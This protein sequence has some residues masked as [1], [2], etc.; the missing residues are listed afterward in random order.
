MVLTTA[1]VS[2]I[3]PRPFRSI[4]TIVST[5]TKE[6]LLGTYAR[7]G[8]LLYFQ[9]THPESIITLPRRNELFNFL[10]RE[11]SEEYARWGR[12][13]KSSEIFYA[14]CTYGEERPFVTLGLSLKIAT[15]I[16][17]GAC[18]CYVHTAL[19]A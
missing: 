3:G 16:V 5:P 15:V 4:N 11:A 19:A 13:G 2:A 10:S 18:S 7:L 6:K 17:V 9:E 12:I 1:S 14:M 8:C